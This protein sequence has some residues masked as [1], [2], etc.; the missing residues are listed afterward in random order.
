[1][2]VINNVVPLSRTYIASVFDLEQDEVLDAYKDLRSRQIVVRM[3]GY[4]R[5]RFPL[6]LGG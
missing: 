2:A 6:A 4:R 5:K 3:T 1:M